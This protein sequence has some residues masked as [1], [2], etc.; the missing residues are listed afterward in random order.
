MFI[1]GCA[2]RQSSHVLFL[3]IYTESP[4][5]T[6]R[7]F[8]YTLLVVSSPRASKLLLLIILLSSL[9]SPRTKT[10]TLLVLQGSELHIAAADGEGERAAGL[11]MVP[12]ARG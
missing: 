6:T 10:R 3:E 12:P 8:A 5:S 1:E 4:C 7:L 11:D 9:L 2:L